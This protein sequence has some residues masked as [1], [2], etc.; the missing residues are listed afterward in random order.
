MEA[1]RP[2]ATQ[3][4]RSGNKS[5]VATVIDLFDTPAFIADEDGRIHTV[6]QPLRKLFAAKK[7]GS[8]SDTDPGILLQIAADQD[9]SG[10]NENIKGWVLL[11][12]SGVSLPC[13]LSRIE[14]GLFAGAITSTVKGTKNDGLR[15][16]MENELFGVMVTTSD[17]LILNANPAFCR[18]IGYSRE[19]LLG[20]EL[21]AFEA[22]S[23]KATEING[24]SSTADQQAPAKTKL[25]KKLLH[26]SGQTIAS[27]AVIHRLDPDAAGQVKLVYTFDDQSISRNAQHAIKDSEQKLKAL[28]ANSR[29]G[30]A[31]LDTQNK[32]LISI[33]P[34]GCSIFDLGPEHI[35]ALQGNK[36]QQDVHTRFISWLFTVAEKPN[37]E[38][39]EELRGKG[40]RPRYIKTHKHELYSVDDPYRVIVFNDVTD[41]IRVREIAVEQENQLKLFVRHIPLPVAMLDTKMNYLLVSENWKLANAMTDN[42]LKG[43]NFFD[44][45]PNLPKRFMESY[46]E[47]LKGEIVE[48]ENDYFVDAGGKGNYVRWEARPWFNSYNEI[49]GVFLIFENITD[50]VMADRILKDHE[51]RFR[52]VFE[53]G[54]VGWLEADIQN[55]YQYVSDLR[56]NGVKDIDSFL[57]NL[58]AEV[59]FPHFKVINYNN[60]IERL[61]GL[62]PTDRL[63]ELR[64]FK[65]IEEPEAL[66]KRELKAI[67]NRE[68]SFDTEF[69]I[70][71]RDGEVKDIH[72]SVNYPE[73]EDFS[74]VIY[75]V[76]DVTEHRKQTGQLRESEERYR[77][78]IDNNHLGIIYRNKV[79]KEIHLNN[80][81]KNILGY[82]IDDVRNITERDIMV[83]EFHSSSKAQYLKL[84]AGEVKSY[85]MELA[86][87]HKNGS[88]IQTNTTVT[89]LYSDKGEFY[90]SVTMIEDIC[91]K[92]DIRKRLKDQNEELS[93]I[94]E[95]LDQF[96]Y[97]A[98]HDLRAPIANVLGLIKL[99]K[100]EEMSETLSN[101]VHL[102]E[103]SLHKLD[104]FIR[105]IVNY[106][107]NAR[108]ELH[109]DE[110][111]LK[112]VLNGILDQY[113]YLDHA[114]KME[115]SLDVTQ[116][117]PF[118]SD[119]KRLTIVLNNIFSNAIRYAD[120][121]K[122]Q[123]YLKVKVR[124][125]KEGATFVIEDNGKGIEEMYLEKIF[126]LFYRADT[127]SKGTGIGLYLVKETVKK[128]NG[129]IKVESEYREWTRFTIF[130]RNL[131]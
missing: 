6:N 5:S 81:F 71:N 43:R 116:E 131:F 60:Q 25:S 119:L 31:L 91:E 121:T 104:D 46:K 112:P 128:L 23:T 90:G 109:L 35:P 68:H 65:M 1:L 99:M 127:N 101:Y 59:L 108:L 52:S 75:G 28:F 93:K 70:V 33:N 110:I 27:K 120:T 10:L 32:K 97:S 42:E 92:K 21:A 103:S 7:L 17:G 15:I 57:K 56:A 86:Y 69:R 76:L 113:R 39:I 74:R 12:R 78:M 36:K 26:K 77:T 94:N 118:V 49:G 106:S 53:S 41:E 19:E 51:L 30:I 47:A 89:G 38:G 62:K 11:I 79:T 126:Q 18:L 55:T 82:Q 87:Y 48:C 123:S 105:S 102:Q 73:S 95:E 34:A 14:N 8:F 3:T 50:R 100:F 58:D 125:N 107:Q 88:V 84:K 115:L 29:H 63:K 98:A 96:V 83:E 117:G 9:L 22:G 13:K 80:A 130:I 111:D 54:S 72:L 122:L 44:V 16:L 64:V 40:G 45:N 37:A 114:Q 24:F 61:F 124:A 4:L 67:F 129:E 20:Q 66:L 2:P 85:N